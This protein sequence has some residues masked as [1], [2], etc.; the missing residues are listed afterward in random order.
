M[1]MPIFSVRTP[2]SDSR[3]ICTHPPLSPKQRVPQPFP[4]RPGSTISTFSEPPTRIY[5]QSV[6]RVMPFPSPI[7]P[8]Y[9]PTLS[10]NEE[11]Y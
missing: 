5:E 10:E 3:R 2:S 1:L 11:K 4:L 7:S 8:T 6:H 9:T